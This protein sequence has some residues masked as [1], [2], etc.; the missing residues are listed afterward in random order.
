MLEQPAMQSYWP[1]P[2]L[3]KA[4]FIAPNAIV[5]GEVT[6]GTGASIWYGAVVR[7]DVERII[8]G[9]RSNVQDGAILHGDPGKV[10]VLEADVTIGHRAVIHGAYIESGCLIGIGATILD[11]VV[12]GSGSIVGAGAVVTKSV[13]PRSLVVGIPGKV[14]RQLSE[15]EAADLITHA[16][17]YEKLAQVHN[18]TGKDLG[19][20]KI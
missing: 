4:A 10:T 16:H 1:T 15:S 6:I 13:P 8:I 19:F 11:G 20:K 14:I 9:D 12:I 5:L 17:N 3:S 2:D 7:A 18:G